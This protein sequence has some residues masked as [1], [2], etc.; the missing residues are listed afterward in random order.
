M[1]DNG[2]EALL[3]DLRDHARYYCRMLPNVGSQDEPD[4]DLREAFGDLH[5]LKV[6]T[7]FPFLLELYGDYERGVL[8]RDDFL[9]A[10]RLIEAYVFRRVV[11]A[12]P[13]NT[14]NK[15]FAGFGRSLRKDRYL[16]SIRA[17][18]PVHAHLP[19]LS[20]PMTSSGAS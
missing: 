19:P 20:R 13:T 6:D 16:E 9:A 1:A 5:E 18:F 10:V 11:C 4:R 2:T 8:G 15:T 7:A 3:R 17:H 12:I 14:L